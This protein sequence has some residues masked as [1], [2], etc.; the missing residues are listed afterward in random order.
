MV[1]HVFNPEHDI[2]LAAHL[3]NFTAPHAARQLRYDLGWIP[4]LWTAESDAVLVDDKQ[5]STDAWSRFRSHSHLRPKAAPPTFVEAKELGDLHIERVEPWGW[6]LAL[7]ALLIRKNVDQLLLPDDKA[8]EHARLLSNRRLAATLLPLLRREGTTGEAFICTADSEIISLSERYGQVVIKAPWSS[9]GR[10]LRFFDIR[11]ESL[12]V[13]GGWL[14]NTI[15]S[16]GAVMVEPYYNKVM[17]F[18][19]EFNADAQGR[20]SFLGLSLFHTKNGAYTGNII[21]TEERKREL[22]SHYLPLSLV[23]QTAA[24]IVLHAGRLLKGYQGPFGV[25]MMVIASAS[26]QSEVCANLLHPCVELNLRR[27]MGHVA[28]DLLHWCN[29][30][31]DNDIQNVMRIELSDHYRLKLER[32]Q[33]KSENV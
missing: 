28:L 26:V 4:A 27:T 5:F 13:H 32:L 25:D 8:L 10:G 29:P 21:A 33:L 1:L 30:T 3:A 16:Q 12:Q 15:T 20:V 14:R 2:A 11:R 22:L 19:M 6:D 9:S 23:D 31:S 24:D 7:R 17:D 18:G